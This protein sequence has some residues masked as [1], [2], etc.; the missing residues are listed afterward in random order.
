VS[1][2]AETRP[3]QPLFWVMES[4][5]K[6]LSDEDFGAIWAALGKLARARG[7]RRGQAVAMTKETT[8]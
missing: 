2:N 6:D 1:N 4:D 5:I 8:T 7:L 3:D